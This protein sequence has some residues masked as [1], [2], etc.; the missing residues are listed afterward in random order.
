[1]GGS[2]GLV[3][4]CNW[5]ARDGSIDGS[6]P[7]CR[8]S[9]PSKARPFGLLGTSRSSVRARH[10]SDRPYSLFVPLLSYRPLLVFLLSVRVHSFSIGRYA[11]CAHH[12]CIVKF[13]VLN[14][15]VYVRSCFQ[16][17]MWRLGYPCPS[18]LFWEEPA[19]EQCSF[20]NHCLEAGAT[21]FL[22]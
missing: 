12:P 2:I 10:F 1:M 7:P 19:G 4:G 18:V 11:S 21:W 16:T 9:P 15:G 3:V 8:P 13:L 17:G 5:L 22:I 14:L 6:A 20:A